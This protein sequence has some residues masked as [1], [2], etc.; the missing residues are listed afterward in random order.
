MTTSASEEIVL[1]SAMPSGPNPVRHRVSIDEPVFLARKAS[2]LPKTLRFRGEL[3][4]APPTVTVPSGV[5]S[6][7]QSFTSLVPALAA[8]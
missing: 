3:K 2:S 1:S 7:F 4:R 8:K 6:V 5:P